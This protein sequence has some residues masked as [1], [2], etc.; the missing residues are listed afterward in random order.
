MKCPFCNNFES[1]VVDKRNSDISIR[2]RRECLKCHERFTTHEKYEV[3]NLII[4][5]KDGRKEIFNRGKLMRGIILA[6]EKRPVNSDQIGRLVNDIEN[7]M[8]NL[9]SSEVKSSLIGELVVKKLM[10]ID[11]IAYI[12]FTSVYKGFEDI[13][14]MEQEIKRINKT[15]E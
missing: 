12:R 13:A 3:Q 5:K 6:C 14:L 15:E 8:K 11:K 7:N 9:G 2:R 10:K 4:S 1:K